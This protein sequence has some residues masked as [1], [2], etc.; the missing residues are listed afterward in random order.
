MTLEIQWLK[1]P[2]DGAVVFITCDQCKTLVI[3]HNIYAV[4]PEDGEAWLFENMCYKPECLR[5]PKV[6]IDRT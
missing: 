3:T 1:Q 6:K 5:R 2:E 4:K